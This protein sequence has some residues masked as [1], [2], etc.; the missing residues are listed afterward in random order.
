[1]ESDICVGVVQ[2][3]ELQ[4]KFID[5]FFFVFFFGYV[6]EKGKISSG[7]YCCA[8]KH[9]ALAV[10][11]ELILEDTSKRSIYVKRCPLSQRPL[12]PR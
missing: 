4:E 1:M 12:K 9:Y 2:P 7:G 3:N 5:L 11:P 6:D 10:A 8:S